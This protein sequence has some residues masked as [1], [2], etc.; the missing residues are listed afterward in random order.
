MTMTISLVRP[1]AGGPWNLRDLHGLPDD[2]NRYELLDGSLLVS[3]PASLPHFRVTTLLR[4]ALEAQAPTSVVVGESVGVAIERDV[5]RITLRVPDLTILHETALHSDEVALDP[6]DVL[7]VVEVLSPDSA[8]TDLIEKRR[9]YAKVGI[10]QYW[11]VDPRRRA[12]NVLTHNG[13]GRYEEAAR[14]TP[15]QRYRATIPFPLTLD[16]ADFV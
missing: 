3:P 8:A 15:G 9:E 16:P 4:R 13:S 2:G 7:L 10:P 11:L 5:R 12:V 6:G 14:I 1:A